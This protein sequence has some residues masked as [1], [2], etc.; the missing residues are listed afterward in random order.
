MR[1]FP[2]SLILSRTKLPRTCW[3]VSGSAI[4]YNFGKKFLLLPDRGPNAVTFD[5]AIDN[6]VSYVNRFHTV[7][8][9][10]DRNFA[11]PLPFT[12]SARLQDTTLLWSLRSAGVRHR[13][14]VGRRLGRSSDQ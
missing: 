14:G 12:L 5:P 1:T 3:A 10:L 8:M 9:D 13:R 4:T 11:G 7:Q 2:A 6:T